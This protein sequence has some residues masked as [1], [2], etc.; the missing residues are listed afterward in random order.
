MLNP[1]GRI[2][3]IGGGCLWE[4]ETF[5][6]DKAVVALSGKRKPNALFIPTATED[7][8]G[9]CEGFE[10]IYGSRLGCKTDT[11]L[12]RRER[13]TMRVIREKIQAADLIYVG[14]GNTLRMMRLWRR[15]GVDALLRSAHRRGVVLAGLSAGA[16]CWYDYG[17]SDSMYYYHPEDWQYIRVKGLGLI[18]ATGCPHVNAE[19]RMG[20]FQGMMKKRPGVGIA[21]DNN[22]AVAYV[23]NE[24]RLLTSTRGAQAYVLRKDGGRVHTEPIPARK[25]YGPVTELF[26]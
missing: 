2:V 3:T 1:K 23:G 4:G 9:Y 25:S 8:D 20:H 16:I 14:G 22:A 24:Y 10:K 7:W 19:N 15:L 26:A 12:L 17:H 6:I 21:M 5:A 18:P 11:L 13:P